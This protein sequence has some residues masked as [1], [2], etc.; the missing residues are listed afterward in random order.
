MNVGGH[1]FKDT[2]AARG[3]GAS[4]SLDQFGYR[5]CLVEKPKS[6]LPIRVA[7]VPRVEKHAAAKQDPMQIS[8][9][10]AVP[11]HVDAFASHAGRA[12]LAFLNV[13]LNR[14]FPEPSI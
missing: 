12:D 6:A 10:S 3:C 7:A 9:Q 1:P 2:A 14:R 11:T 5:I 8:N 13:A 4:G